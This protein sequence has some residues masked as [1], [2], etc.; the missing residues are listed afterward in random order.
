MFSTDVELI[1]ELQEWRK[2]RNNIAPP[3]VE[4]FKTAESVESESEPIKVGN[5]KTVTNSSSVNQEYIGWILKKSDTQ[6]LLVKFC[7]GGNPRVGFHCQGWLGGDRGFSE[8]LITVP[9]NSGSLGPFFYPKLYPLSTQPQLT[10]KSGLLAQIKDTKE[11]SSTLK[12]KKQSRYTKL[13]N[14]YKLRKKTRKKT[15]VH[16]SK[17]MCHSL[18]VLLYTDIDRNLSKICLELEATSTYASLSEQKTWWSQLA[19]PKHTIPHNSQTIYRH[20]TSSAYY[21]PTLQSY[22]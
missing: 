9:W 15:S 3:G 2:A 8:D 14:P 6:R 5:T 18:Y 21:N 10:E 19:R 17:R 16:Q 4:S 1:A 13:C 7:P 22:R 11:W 20:F 12:E